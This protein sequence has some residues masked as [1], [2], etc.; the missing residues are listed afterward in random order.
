M[1]LP[2]TVVVAFQDWVTVVAAGYVSFTVHDLIADVPAVTFT[3]A[4]KPPC[5]WLLS[6]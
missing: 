2:A 3:S 6:E 5:H 4:W 1:V